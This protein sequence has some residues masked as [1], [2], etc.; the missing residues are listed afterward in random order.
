MRENLDQWDYVIACY[1]V[2]IVAT[3][4]MIVWAWISMRRSE[5][6]RDEVKRK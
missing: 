3:G 2:G 5:Q 6:R 1:A 4:V